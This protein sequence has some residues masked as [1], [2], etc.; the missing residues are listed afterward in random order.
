MPTHSGMTVRELV[1]E[2]VRTRLE[3][4]RVI[5]DPLNVTLRDPADPGRMTALER[6]FG[7]SL[8]ASYREFLG[9]SDGVPGFET[10]FDLLGTREM[11]GQEYEDEVK[12]IRHLAWEVGEPG[13][14]EG[15]I[16]GMRHGSDQVVYLDRSRRGEGGECPVVHWRYEPLGEA[17]SFKGF[18]EMWLDIVQGILRDAR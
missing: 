5:G 10:Q 6:R 9:T 16:V 11:L 8:P 3:I 15:W 1:E 2:I 7:A 14:L 18:L 13:P 17:P 12:R 4:V